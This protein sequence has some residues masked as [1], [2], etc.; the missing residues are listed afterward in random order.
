MKKGSLAVAFVLAA[1]FATGGAEAQNGGSARQTERGSPCAKPSRNSMAPQLTFPC[2]GARLKA[3]HNIVWR[4][5]DINPD[6]KHRFYYPYLNVTRNRPRHGVLPSDANG[7]GIYAQMRP[8]KGHPGSFR[9]QAKRYHFHG[10]W[11]V[12]KGTWYVQA[13]QVDHSGSGKTLYSPI[14]KVTIR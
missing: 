14:E 6:A 5:R 10:Y 3:G 13:Q 1:A 2:A 4:V 7:Y 11:L 8:V 9:Y 12:T